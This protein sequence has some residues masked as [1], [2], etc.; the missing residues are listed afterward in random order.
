MCEPLVKQLQR[1][2][3]LLASL[4]ASEAMASGLLP[5]GEHNRLIRVLEN[6]PMVFFV[7]KGPPDSCGKDCNEWIAAV[8]S[9]DDGASQRFR[10]LVEKLGGRN[11]PVFF[12]SPGGLAGAGIRI[13]TILRERRM[14]AGVG[15]TEANCR[16]F[17]K[18]DKACQGKIATGE[19]VAAR[20]LMGDASC[21][22]ACVEAFAGASS[23]H[24][25][26]VAQLGVH[27]A[28]NLSQKELLSLGRTESKPRVTSVGA[29]RQAARRYYME[30]G[31][32][33]DL[34][35]FASKTPHD[36]IYVLDRSEIARFGLE[37][38]S[39]SYETPWATSDI[40]GNAFVVMKS[41]TRRSPSDPAE[42]LTTR[43]TFFCSRGGK[44]MIGYRR[45]LPRDPDQATTLVR[46]SF[47]HWFI[48]L[49]VIGTL[50][51]METGGFAPELHQETLA[52]FVAA[53][54]LTVT[55]KMKTGDQNVLEGSFSN[56]GLAEALREFQN[57]CGAGNIALRDP[58][59]ARPQSEPM[60]PVP[61][62][63]VSVKRTKRV[64]ASP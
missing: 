6:R 45:D 23:R 64:R 22:S 31:V 18:K 2:M 41:V 21:F 3:I 44:P 12:H 15:R 62:K 36:R 25:A 5:P 30:M 13:G 53:K 11:L 55:E 37:T 8:G 9:F 19:A 16:V 20:L 63:P 17:D 59:A 57:R 47:D 35:D 14:T 60:K 50:E 28:R 51:S 52:K 54:T 40:S 10:D 48:E 33:P 58:P 34:T 29:F 7:A 27:A 46:L 24:I 56:A 42:N 49:R 4:A 43:L 32:N 39:D 26:S 1:L 61:V 38:R